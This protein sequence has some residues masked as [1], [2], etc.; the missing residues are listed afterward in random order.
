MFPSPTLSVP[1]RLLV[2]CKLAGIVQHHE[3]LQQ[4]LD[5]LPGGG[6]GAD[7]KLLG[8]VRGQVEGR[9]LQVG[10]TLAL[11]RDLAATAHLPGATLQ[12]RD[13]HS[14][15]GDR[16]AEPQVDSDEAGVGAV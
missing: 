11:R 9:S 12:G 13:V 5:D 14:G 16:P 2:Q 3:L 6:V 1:V 15:D 10:G 8:A 4:C 7:V